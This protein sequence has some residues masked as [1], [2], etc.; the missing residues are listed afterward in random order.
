MIN[1]RLMAPLDGYESEPDGLFHLPGSVNFLGEHE[2]YVRLSLDLEPGEDDQYP[3][4]DVL[5]GYNVA[6]GGVGDQISQ[7]AIDQDGHVTSSNDGVMPAEGTIEVVFSGQPEE[8]RS[9][10]AGIVGRRVYNENV[11]DGDGYEVVTLKNDPM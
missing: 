4:E 2:W 9:L 10:V 1:I 11:T 6:V 7:T 5:D 3:L 8:L